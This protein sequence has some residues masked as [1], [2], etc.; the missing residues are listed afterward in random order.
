MNPTAHSD[1]TLPSRRSILGSVAMCMATAVSG[2]TQERDRPVAVG[3]ASLDVQ[4]LAGGFDL[5]QDEIREWVGS[6]A[7]A[8]AGYLGA[9]PV[10]NARIADSG[11]ENHSFR[12]EENKFAAKRHR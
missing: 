1:P 4:F 3:S 8:V 11:E 10:R 5:T 9:F 2:R 6:C 12:A 7:Q